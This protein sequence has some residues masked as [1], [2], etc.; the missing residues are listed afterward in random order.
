MEAVNS[1]TEGALV[2]LLVSLIVV[3]LVTLV[4]RLV[5]G[6]RVK[7]VSMVLRDRRQH[8][9]S[10]VFALSAMPTH[11]WVPTLPTYAAGTMAFWLLALGLLAWDVAWWRK[12]VAEFPAWARVVKD[13]RWWVL[14]GLVSG[15]V[16]FP[17]GA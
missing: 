3:E 15:L 12:S 8:T 17:Q 6:P 2:T 1:W 10:V 5:F 16:L 4:G 13:S 7:T 14:V 11:W 9:T